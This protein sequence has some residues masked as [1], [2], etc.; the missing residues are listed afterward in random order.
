M[1]NN[2]RDDEPMPVI[3]PT[4]QIFLFRRAADGLP[5]KKPAPDGLDLV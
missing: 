4:G 3:C 5:R 1:R 2:R